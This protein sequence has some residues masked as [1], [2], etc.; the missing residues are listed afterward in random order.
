MRGIDSNIL[1][2]DLLDA[3]DLITTGKAL[4]DI[5]AFLSENATGRSAF[6]K[7]L[8]RILTDRVLSLMS[9]FLFDSDRYVIYPPAFSIP[10]YL[11]A[12]G[13]A[14]GKVCDTILHIRKLIDYIDASVVSPSG[15][16]LTRERTERVLQ[17]L[18]AKFPYFDVVSKPLHILCIDNTDKHFNSQCGVSASGDECILLMF[19][20]KDS[21]ISPEYVFLHELGHA[22]QIA[23]TGSP[24]IVPEEFI[25]FH[26]SLNSQLE[27]GNP[28]APD[29]FADTFAMAVMRGTE[30]SLHDPFELSDTLKGA[31][32][33]FIAGLFQ[34]YQ[35]RFENASPGACESICDNNSSE[36]DICIQC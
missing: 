25:R 26:Q 28:D 24:E 6:C 4:K 19:H 16:C 29:V 22:L 32:E 31:I 34:K 35:L 10:A 15:N 13:L 18:M 1:I 21:A 27:Q 17:V 12:N 7:K 14:S 33:C 8:S 30:L 5:D 9:C 2:W 20:M 23:L 11:M 3:T 36:C